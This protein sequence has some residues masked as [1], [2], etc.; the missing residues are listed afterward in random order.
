MKRIA[1]FGLLCGALLLFVT[2][3]GAQETT[4][5]PSMTESMAHSV[6]PQVYANLMNQMMTNPVGILTDPISTCTQCHSEEDV[7][8]YKSEMGPML[9]MMSPVNWMNPT[10]YMQMMNVPMDPET[11]AKWY[12]GWMKKYSGMLGKAEPAPEQ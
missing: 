12:E 8:R 7:E 4:T 1:I 5:A 6:D 9:Q 10:A 3:S 11:Y 2:P